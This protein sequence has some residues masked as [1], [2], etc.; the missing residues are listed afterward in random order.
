MKDIENTSRDFEHG[1]FQDFELLLVFVIRLSLLVDQV[2]N[3]QLASPDD[4]TLI[5]DI[6]RQYY[7][8]V[9]DIMMT[10]THRRH[11]WFCSFGIIYE[12]IWTVI[13]NCFDNN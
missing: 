3:L 8:S 13:R 4:D 5:I 10:V 1:I 12:H 6:I 9:L 7:S 2:T 11:I